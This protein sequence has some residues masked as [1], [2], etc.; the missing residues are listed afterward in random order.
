MDKRFFKCVHSPNIQEAT[1]YL[2]ASKTDIKE[3]FMSKLYTS[4]SNIKQNSLRMS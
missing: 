4:L 3:N 2:N 1:S